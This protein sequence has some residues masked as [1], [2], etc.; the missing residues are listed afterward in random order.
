[1]AALGRFLRSV[2]GDRVAFN[3]PGCGTGHVIAIGETAS[4]RWS[5]NGDLEKPTFAPSVLTG[6]YKL[7]AKG[8]EELK[9]WYDKGMP[10]KKGEQFDGAHIVCHS[11]IT[12][13]NIQFLADSTHSLSGQTVPLPDF[14]YGAW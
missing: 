2:D 8:K 13:G 9:E 7:S 12:D 4:P 6:Y 5:F 10:D 3:C 11:Y 1:M 14:D